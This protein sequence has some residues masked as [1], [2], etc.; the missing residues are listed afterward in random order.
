MEVVESS[1][2]F[3]F[4]VDWSEKD[5]VNHISLGAHDTAHLGHSIPQTLS[6]FGNKNKTLIMK[7]FKYV[8][9]IT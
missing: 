8:L 1:R 9:P 5:G 6:I 4:L 7:S 2:V 3:F